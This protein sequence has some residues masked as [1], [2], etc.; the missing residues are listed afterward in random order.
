[1][2]TQ[3]GQ[4][5]SSTT[6]LRG[7]PASQSPAPSSGSRRPIRADRGRGKGKAVEPR[8]PTGEPR[9]TIGTLFTMVQSLTDEVSALRTERDTSEHAPLKRQPSN[10]RYTSETPPTTV[11]P[12]P[13]PHLSPARFLSIARSVTTNFDYGPRTYKT[14][15]VQTLSDGIDP[16]YKA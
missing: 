14:R 11:P 12:I 13:D 4:P 5:E 8:R 16:T 6:H 10:F 1:M 7:S 9:V 2:A 15:D 3:D